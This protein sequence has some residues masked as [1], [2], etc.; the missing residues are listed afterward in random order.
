M[1]E[2]KSSI[3][4]GHRQG[5]KE[6]FLKQGLSGMR[7]HQILELLLFYAVP[8]RDVNPL[9][10]RLVEHFG[11]LAGVFHAT[12]DQLLEV[13]GVGPNIATLLLLVPA[14]SARYL[15][16][17]ASVDGQIMATW[18]L[19]ELLIP[20]FFGLRDEA[21]YLVCMD[22]KNKVL[23]TR[24]LGQG[25]VDSVPIATRKV[26]EAALGCNASRVVLAHNHVSGVALWSPADLDTTL[27]LKRLLAEA[28][29]VLV[30]HVIL[31]GDDMISMAES[32]LLG[33]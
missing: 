24:K 8:R 2:K 13:E 25:V 14:A 22:G 17:S 15:E 20:L 26:L 12:Y 3:H 28:D 21:A 4:A 9:A 1:G 10:H 5:M 31:A 19:R 23:A 6:Q 11:S 29:I 33:D 18:Q 30:D 32:G 16:E 27:R 7:D